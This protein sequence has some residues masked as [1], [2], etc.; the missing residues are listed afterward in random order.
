MRYILVIFIIVFSVS[1]HKV[2]QTELE[3]NRDILISHEWGIPEIEQGSLL[4][5][6]VFYNSP[7]VF[8]DDGNV[9]F[10]TVYQD[11]WNFLDER[12][13]RFQN[14]GVDW[15]FIAIN[16]SILHVNILK[17]NT[18]DF[19]AECIYKSLN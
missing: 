12:T 3:K 8:S 7:T 16:D 14:T 9:E 11:Y 2:D 17:M 13:V 18:A 19:I 1:C 15:N 6:S 4:S 10:G 5:I